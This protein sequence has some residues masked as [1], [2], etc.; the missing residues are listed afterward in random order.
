MPGLGRRRGGGRR[1][2]RRRAPGSEVGGRGL[3]GRGQQWARL[4][5]P[6]RAPRRVQDLSNRLWGLAEARPAHAGGP[7][8]SIA[9]RS[10]VPHTQEDRRS[11]P[12]PRKPPNPFENRKFN[13]AQ[14]SQAAA[15]WAGAPSALT[16]PQQGAAPVPP[17]SGP[18]AWACTR[19][20]RRVAQA[21]RRAALRA[22]PGAGA[23]APAA[24][25]GALNGGSQRPAVRLLSQ[26][27]TPLRASATVGLL[28]RC[29]HSHTGAARGSA[30]AL[31]RRAPA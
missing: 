25:T 11:Q 24:A 28:S 9:S 7:V 30:R 18:A 27:Q 20:A 6:Q 14:R 1:A 29:P 3:G 16:P 13:R 19:H 5:T 2:R 21:T 22:A 17:H 31:A 23:A 10:N 15:G 26:D 8:Q 4:A 12:R